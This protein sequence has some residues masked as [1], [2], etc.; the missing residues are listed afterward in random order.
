MVCALDAN[1]ST[2]PPPTSSV[3]DLT[4]FL[5]MHLSAFASLL[6]PLVGGKV[7]CEG[8][9][10]PRKLYVKMVNGRPTWRCGCFVE[11]GWSDIRQVS[12]LPSCCN[13]VGRCVGGCYKTL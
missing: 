5:P 7:W 1:H 10:Y 4:A 12:L 9:R 8:G 3:T 6:T 13:S 11:L 2:I